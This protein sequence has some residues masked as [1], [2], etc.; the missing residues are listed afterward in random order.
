MGVPMAMSR[1]PDS[2]ASNTAS[3]ACTT[4]NSVELCSAAR[5]RSPACT[6][7]STVKPTV[8]PRLEATA[9]RGRS[10]G[11]SSCSTRPPSSRC[12]KAI[13]RAIS[14]SGSSSA[15]STSRCHSA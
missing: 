8:A 6:S 13:W 15:P 12:Q 14:D 4:M 5:P 10:V 1:V 9:G 11:R 7:G 3:A 2:R